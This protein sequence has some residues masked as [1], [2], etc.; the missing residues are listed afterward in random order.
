M[1]FE[2]AGLKGPLS[3]Q[4]EYIRTEL[5]RDTVSDASFAGYYILASVFPWGGSRGYFIDK[6]VFGRP[7]FDQ[8][9]GAWEF[10]VRFD[11]LDLNDGAITGG[12]QENWN[13]GVNFYRSFYRVSASYVDTTVTGGVN[14]NEDISAFTIMLQTRF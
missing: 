10:A 2:L 5:E 8:E 9:R 12:V 3:V 13:L 1:S 7:D 11:R 14:G 6:G 4:A